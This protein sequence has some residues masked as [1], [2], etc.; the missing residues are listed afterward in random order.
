[1]KI[2]KLK[3]RQWAGVGFGYTGASYGIPERPDIR[4]LRE[5]HGW[6]AYIGTTKFFGT[7][8]AEL[9]AELKPKE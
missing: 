1:M 5:S 4:I 8:K 7:T 6:I 3:P 2:V 9:E